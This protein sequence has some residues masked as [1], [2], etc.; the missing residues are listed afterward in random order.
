MRQ[1]HEIFRTDYYRGMNDSVI[2][3]LDLPEYNSFSIRL[4]DSRMDT[5]H[6]H[7]MIKIVLLENTLER[8]IE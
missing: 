6:I 7:N 4:R 2:E 3:H 5:I 8:N 1:L